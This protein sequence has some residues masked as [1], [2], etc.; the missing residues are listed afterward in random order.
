[1]CCI[2]VIPLFLGK[3]RDG[4]LFEVASWDKAGEATTVQPRMSFRLHVDLQT[5]ELCIIRWSSSSFQILR[6]AVGSRKQ[7]MSSEA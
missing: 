1:V 7:D 2:V 6:G 4:E 5:T 3:L